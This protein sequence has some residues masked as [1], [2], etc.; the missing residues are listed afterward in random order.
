M[1]EVLDSLEA[2]DMECR[3][4]EILVDNTKVYYN[5]ED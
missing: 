4:R 3:R 1:E 5:I 2:I